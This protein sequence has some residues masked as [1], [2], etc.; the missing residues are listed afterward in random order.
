M[1]GVSGCL[2]DDIGLRF[3]H[4]LGREALDGRQDILKSTAIDIQGRE[5][6]STDDGSD[7]KSDG[8]KED[9]SAEGADQNQ[10]VWHL[11]VLSDECR[12]QEIVDGSDHA[13]A[14]DSEQDCGKRGTGHKQIDYGGHPHQSSP[15][16]RDNRQNHYD[17][18]PESRSI[19]SGEVE[20]NTREHPLDQTNQEG[21]LDGGSCDGDEPFEHSDFVFMTKGHVIKDPLQDRPAVLQ[22]EEHRIQHDKKL[23]KESGCSGGE[24]GCP[25]YKKAS[26]R[27]GCCSDVLDD[28]VTAWQ[29][30][31]CPWEALDQPGFNVKGTG[32]AKSL[33]EPGNRLLTYG[34]RLVD[35]QAQEGAER[36]HYDEKKDHE[37]CGRREGSAPSQESDH[38]AKKRMAKT[39]QDRSDQQS[40]KKRPH[41]RREQGGDRQNE[42]EHKCCAKPFAVDFGR[43]H[44]FR[45]LSEETN[46]I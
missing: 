34:Q 3:D 22:E 23:E 40:L 21:S 16:R 39:G 33:V 4:R 37:S 44:D 2:L 42:N 24:G 7:D 20:T 25:A 36:S 30:V 29:E 8:P 35:Y 46:P 10:E 41:H 45:A 1:L 18:A 19:D 14:P 15:D 17:G 27:L 38:G 43:F 26:C 9:E 11:G 6:E 28:L 12:P 31:A 5:K 32:R 13:G